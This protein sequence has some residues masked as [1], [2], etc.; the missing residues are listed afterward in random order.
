V[1]KVL[2]AKPSFT[3]AQLLSKLKNRGLIVN[4][5]RSALAYL[6]H[7]GG[8]RLKGYYFHVVDPVTKQFPAGYTF[9]QIAERYE[10]DRALRYHTFSVITRLEMAI[11]STIANHLSNTYG[12]HWFLDHTIFEHTD[13]WSLG[14][15][16]RKIED[17]TDRSRSSAFIEHYKKKFQEPYLPPSWGVTE[18][19]TFGMWSL[20]YNALKEDK[21]KKAV[22]VKFKVQQSAIF[23][24][25]LH[26]ITVLRNTVAH[27]SRLL[28]HKFV[29]GPQNLRDKN[30]RF[31]DCHTFYSIATVMN[32]MLAATGLP[33]TWKADLQTTFAAHPGVNIGEIGFPANWATQP[34]W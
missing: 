10:F 26:A 24:S 16:I 14:K 8:Y 20:T 23:G 18:C 29:A 17:E 31:T 22:S 9:E 6:Q 3:P 15:L 2:F 27:H 30:I 33:N 5:D 32:Y 12:A 13:K 19:V 34:G 11:R 25:W 28:R 4:D 1:S 7:V 21:D